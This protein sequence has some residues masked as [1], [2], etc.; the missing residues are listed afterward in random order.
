[1]TK[2]KT[3]W[4]AIAM[5][6]TM[7]TAG[8]RRST[9]VKLIDE[10]K[11]KTPVRTVALSTNTL[12]RS[13]V[14][15]ASIHAY[16]ESHV[17][18]QATGVV[19]EIAVDIGDVVKKGD[20]LLKIEVPELLMQR[21]ILRA[22]VSR[23]EA[24]ERRESAGVE[25]AAAEVT[26]AEAQ[27]SEAKSLLGQID[28]S[29]AASESEF[30]RTEDLVNRG[31]LQQRVLDEVRKKRDSEAAAK[32]SASA[33]IESS[34]AMVKVAMAKQTAAAADLDAAKAE[35]EIA[36]RQLDEI[37]VLIDFAS[38]RAS[39]EGVITARNV[40]PGNL[41][42]PDAE[43]SKPLLVISQIDKVRVRIPVPEIEAAH[44]SR[45]DQV[46][47]SFPSFADEP[48][49]KGTIARTTSALTPQSRTMLAEVDLENGEG[50]FLPGMFGQ[51]SI[52]MAAQTTAKTLP[53]RAIHFGENGKAHVY[54]VDAN[55]IVTVAQIQTG[56]DDG[57]MIEVLSGLDPNARVIDA[58]LHRFTDGESVQVLD[59]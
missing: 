50:K 25:L 12:E 54:V 35:T 19:T 6:V 31:S 4:L 5:A 43:G 21:E 41:V 3:V 8:C 26:S 34:Q 40:E 36:R 30:N 29:L 48:P 1:M 2:K 39:I 52:Q 59:R 16:Y 53:S 22:K 33:A 44:V 28:A 46:S 9:D 57:L 56:Q 14:Q 11:F 13:T 55:D 10:D 15:P 51:A 38:V 17:R 20:V 32:Q 24:A 45:G 27:L 58:N 47:L 7:T 49:I 37:E 42:G 18:P 23:L